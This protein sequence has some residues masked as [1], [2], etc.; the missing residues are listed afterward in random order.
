MDHRLT[1][2][3]LLSSALSTTTSF[4][5][6]P[7]NVV[8]SDVALNTAAGTDAL[9]NLPDGKAGTIENTAFGAYA[10]FNGLGSYNTTVGALALEHNLEAT[11]SPRS[12]RPRC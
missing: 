1:K 10:D 7:P 3:L 11:T 5:A 6:Q 2:A 9:R 8:K 4:S 12:V